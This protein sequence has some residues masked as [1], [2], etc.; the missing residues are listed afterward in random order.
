M[1]TLTYQL[2]KMEKDDPSDIWFDAI[3]ANFAQIDAHNHDGVTS[4][5][6]Q[7]GVAVAIIQQTI[8]AS[9]WGA[10]IGNGRYRQLVT[11]PVVGT[12][13]LTYDSISMEFKL[14]STKAVVYPTVEKV[15]ATTFY[16]YT[17]DNTED[18]MALY[19]S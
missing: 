2:K 3:A 10:S 12:T 7:S 11:L 16:V 15:S 17:V 18:F 5:Q 14:G 6:L 4:A 13:Q 9:A 8:L 1:L 19:S